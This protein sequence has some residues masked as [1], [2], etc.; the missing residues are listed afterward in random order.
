MRFQLQAIAGVL[1]ALMLDSVAVAE[2]RN[3]LERSIDQL[4]EISEPGFGY[5]VYFAG[6]E[7]L[8]YEDTGEMGVLVLGAS[9]ATR[10]DTLRK[11]VEKGADAVPALL[12][13]INDART[14][15]MRP[16]D[17]SGI[18]GWMAF[19]DEYDY[20]RRTRKTPPKG[21]NRDDHGSADDPRQHA[22][23]V[24]DLCFVALGQIVNRNFSATRYQPSGGVIVS[25]PTC[26]AALR[27]VILDDWSGLTR[28]R[29]KKLLIDDFVNADQ[30]ERRIGA[31]RRLAFYYPEAVEPLVLKQLAEPYYDV[32]EVE[33]FVREKL[34]PARDATERKKLLN[35]FVAK[36][37]EVARQGILLQLF[38]DLNTQEADEQERLLPPLEE[39][40]DARMC[41]LELFGYPKDVKSENQPCLFPNEHCTQARFIESLTHDTSQKVG[42]VVRKLFLQFPD[43]DCFRRPV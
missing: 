19:D 22:I 32:F 18:M 4:V 1:V 8:P 16:V 15:K 35:A 33:A 17:V 6:G 10:S 29:H 34:Y 9:H 38:D 36:R 5:S 25:S 23:T 28:E 39:K 11:I 3:G 26:S 24:G 7:F 2:E 13:H 40:S 37:G 31:Y 14:I 12:K 43:D 20:N 41:L 27:K 21:V 42:D 30:E